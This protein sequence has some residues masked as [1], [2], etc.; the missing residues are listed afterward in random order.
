MHCGFGKQGVQGADELEFHSDGSWDGGLAGAGYVI[1]QPFT[2]KYVHTAI[3]LSRIV[4]SDEA[5]IRAWAAVLDFIGETVASW[6]GENGNRVPTNFT[7]WTDSEFGIRE[8]ERRQ[9]GAETKHQAILD[10]VLSDIETLANYGVHVRVRW[11][12]GKLS[13]GAIEADAAAR[14]G[15][16]MARTF[17]G[18]SHKPT[19]YF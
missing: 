9:T 2:S 6:S 12:R 16:Q 10:V 5:E 7:I 8:A 15:L 3:P 1:W 17:A 4:D 11:E 19:I 13:E 18:T 14:M